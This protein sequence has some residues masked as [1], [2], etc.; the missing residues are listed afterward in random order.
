MSN[1]SKR[2]S[3]TASDPMI[4]LKRA[5]DMVA[6]ERIDSFLSSAPTAPASPVES[7]ASLVESPPPPKYF[8]ESPHYSGVDFCFPSSFHSNNIRS[9]C[10]DFLKT[11]SN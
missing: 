9:K 5:V 3:G 8:V 10:S 1:H 4:E 2:K 6:L 7:P 11:V